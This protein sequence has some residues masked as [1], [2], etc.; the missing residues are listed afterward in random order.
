MLDPAKLAWGLRDACLRSGVR[1]YEHT[2]V[3][4]LTRQGRDGRTH[5]VRVGAGRSGR[6]GHQRVPVAGA[7]VRP[8]V[9]PVYDYV[10]MTEPLTAEQLAAIGWKDRQGVGDAGNQFHYYR[11]DAD[12]RI[13][14]GGYDAIY[15]YGDRDRARSTSSGRTTYA[16]SPSTSSRPS[17]SWRACASPTR[18][19]GAIDTCTRFCAFC[20]TAH[21]GPGRLRRRL[22]RARASARPGSAPTCCSTC[23]TARHR[24]APR[25]EMVRRSR[26]RSRRSRCAGPASSS[27]GGRSRAR[28]PTAAG[29]TSG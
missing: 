3:T 20:G 7:R 4:A 16:S 2:P 1:V 8:Y 5:G 13:L 27:P 28:T 12:N 22:H 15:H 29:G 6:A 25:L 14:W 17:R 23:W 21:G 26:C 19:G 9:V 10:L 24:A 11:L 18:W